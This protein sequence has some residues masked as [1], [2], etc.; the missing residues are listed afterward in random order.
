MKQKLEDSLGMQINSGP[1]QSLVI[2][3]DEE[4]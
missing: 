1:K 4:I 3:G 2:A